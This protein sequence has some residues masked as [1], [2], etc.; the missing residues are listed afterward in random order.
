[1]SSEARP[2]VSVRS[3]ASDGHK[4]T[5]IT[6]YSPRGGVGRTFAAYNVGALLAASGRRTL[7]VDFD[8]EQPGLT[9][10]ADP[11]RHARSGMVDLL[12][13]YIRNDGSPRSWR[14]VLE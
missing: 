2:D 9:L 13:A 8:L 7:L 3:G 12:I 6:F 14:S 10:F 4:P 5:I 1:M 11:D